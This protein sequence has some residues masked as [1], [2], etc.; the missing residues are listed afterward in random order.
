ML[1]PLESATER[2]TWPGP[3]IRALCASVHPL[4]ASVSMLKTRYRKNRPPND[5]YQDKSHGLHVSS[6]SFHNFIPDFQVVFSSSSLD[7]DASG[8]SSVGSIRQRRQ[9]A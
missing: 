2:T 5:L 7:L 9:R 1:L 3:L 4:G 8:T 6:D